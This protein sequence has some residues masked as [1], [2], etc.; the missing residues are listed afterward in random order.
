[1]DLRIRELRREAKVTQAE[2]AKLISVDTKTIGNWERGA[3][4]P[5]AKQ[6]WDCAV[7]LKCT[8]NDILGWEWESSAAVG[9]TFDE[10]D[11]LNNYRDLTPD[12]KRA[13]LTTASD[14][15]RLSRGVSERR[16]GRFSRTA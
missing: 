12:R 16:E 11:L 13:L 2:L 3:T 14:G 10:T 1:M 9:L 15:A 5:D 7:A 4:E 8:P 6:V